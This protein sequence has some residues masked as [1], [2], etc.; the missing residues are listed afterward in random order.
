MAAGGYYDHQASG[1]NMICLP[2]M[3]VYL[4]VQP[5]EQEQASIYTAEYKTADFPPFT[6]LQNQD[7]PCAVCGVAHRGSMIMVPAKVNCP[8]EWM[9]EY[10]G[11]LMTAHYNHMGTKDYVCVDEMATARNDSYVNDQDGAFLFPVE[12][13]CAHG[14]LP[15][16]PYVDGDEL[17]C[18]VCTK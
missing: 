11:Y 16:R 12:A 10:Q 18:V 13:R 6:Q 15:C 3:P 17:T 8:S 7:I 14:N 2:M 1:S 9:E 4:S 5:D